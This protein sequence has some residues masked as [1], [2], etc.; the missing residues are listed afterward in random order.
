MSA[1]EQRLSPLPGRNESFRDD[2]KHI[3]NFCTQKVE[4]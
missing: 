2:L 3:S 4:K 1:P